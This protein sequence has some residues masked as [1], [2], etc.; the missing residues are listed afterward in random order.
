VSRAFVKEEDGSRPETLPELPVSSLPNLV[1]PRGL[2]L[3][4]DRVAEI[5]AALAAEPDETRVA[6]LRRDLRYWRLRHAT[7][8]LTL[9]D[10]ADPS[11]QF[12]SRVTYRTEAGETR[13]VVL[14]GEDEADPAAG[15]IAYAAPVARALTGALAGTAVTLDLRGHPVELEVLAVEIPAE[16]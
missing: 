15:T 7:A 2:R 13:T 4:E 3:I 1:T 14:T 16:G 11:V 6:R 9:P 8:R 12:G 10:P 5:E